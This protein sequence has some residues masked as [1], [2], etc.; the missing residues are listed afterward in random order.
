MQAPRPSRGACSSLSLPPAHWSHHFLRKRHPEITLHLQT[1]TPWLPVI[2]HLVTPEA[3]RAIIR[4][5]A[6]RGRSWG[7]GQDKAG[8]DE[9]PPLRCHQGQWHPASTATLPPSTSLLHSTRLGKL[10]PITVPTGV[11]A[12]A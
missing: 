9:S 5:R 7:A 11:G 3:T 4:I 12:L 1:A 6:Q 10:S 2:R 8:L